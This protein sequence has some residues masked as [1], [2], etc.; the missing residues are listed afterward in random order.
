[1]NCNTCLGVWDM[2]IQTK[3][4]PT[5]SQIL[6]CHVKMT[7]FRQLISMDKAEKKW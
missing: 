6:H 4:A 3:F 7:V 2:L 5:L 1:M